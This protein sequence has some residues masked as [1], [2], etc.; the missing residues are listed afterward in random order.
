MTPVPQQVRRPPAQLHVLFDGD[1]GF[2]RFWVER[3]RAD[4]R[5]PA[6]FEPFQ[7]AA[8]RYPEIPLPAFNEAVQAVDTD[9]KIYS[10]ADAVFRLLRKSR[11]HWIT[12]IVD[13]LPILRRWAHAVY[14]FI[15][16]HR[17]SFSKLTR[18]AWGTIA[19]PPAFAMARR[20]FAHGLGFVFF[21]AFGSLALQWKG[22]FGSRGILPLEWMDRA[23]EQIGAGIY[24]RVPSVFWLGHSDGMI[25]AV[26]WAGVLISLAMM[27]GFAPGACAL[28]LW[29]LYLSI[30]SVSQPFLGYQWDALL[31]ETAL[32]AAIYLPWSV[33]PHW[34]LTTRLTTLGR[35]LLWWL[36][37]RLMLESGIV[38]LASGDPTWRN[39]TAL[40]Y[41]YE[42]Q[43]LPLWTAWFAH[44]APV[45]FHQLEALATF[46]I[47]FIAPL[48]IFAPR[49]LRHAGAWAMIA[50][51]LGIGLTGNYAFFNLLCILLSLLLLEDSF[52][53]A[54]WRGLLLR[55]V[56]PPVHAGA[57]STASWILEPVGILSAIFTGVLLLGTVWRPLLSVSPLD[58]LRKVIAPLQSFNSYGLFASM[59]TERP[60][61]IVE[62]SNDG[63]NWQAYEFKWKPGDLNRRPRLAEPH[64][65]RLD[66]QM[67]FAA[68]SGDARREPWFVQFMV[69]LLQGS[70][71][72]VALLEW[73]PFP[74]TPPQ[75]VRARLYDYHFTR[76][77]EGPAWWKRQ[78]IGEFC[79]A[80]SLRA[81]EEK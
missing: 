5:E 19:A 43:P 78:L 3:W 67:W 32:I 61:I 31:L 59:T 50:L 48:L 62:G 2:C 45:W 28:V 20:I 12:W 49:R 52:Y 76:F 35:W 8:G 72:V 6:R 25:A 10:G 16:S 60:E 22:L 71:D 51:Q 44:Q 24:W 73:N 77:G 37:C 18:L 58:S 57:P 34:R 27:C 13:D 81:K 1:C 4:A 74:G 65:P 7:Q 63:V 39:L 55:R 29:A 15:A 42:T 80:I 41:H 46:A 70:P 79:P 64:Q 26:I 30:C 23:R 11:W 40:T 69:R 17:P 14:R 33:R 36:L 47:E 66:W 38:K 56:R 68:L 53:P 75:Y 9:G 21:A 54:A